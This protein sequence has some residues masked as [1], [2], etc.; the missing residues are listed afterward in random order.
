MAGRIREGVQ[1]QE[2]QLAALDDEGPAVISGRQRRAEHTI[3]ARPRGR[4]IPHPPRRPETIHPRLRI[5]QLAEPLPDL[6]DDRRGPR[7]P[8]PRP[9]PRNQGCAGKAGAR[10]ELVQTCSYVFTSSRSRL[11]TLKNGTRFSGTL[12]ASPVLGFRPLREFRCRIRKLPNPRSSTLSPLLRASVMLSKTVLTISS[13]SFFVRLA[14]W[15]TSSINSAL[16]MSPLPPRGTTPLPRLT[17]TRT[18]ERPLPCEIEVCQE[19]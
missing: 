17:E 15:A 14:S 8:P 6:E 13:V 12:T 3:R 19:G 2:G 16:V 7:R 1:D 10:T 11:P 9:P 18:P 5:D 4:D